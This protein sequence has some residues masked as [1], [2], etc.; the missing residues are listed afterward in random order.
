MPFWNSQAETQTEEAAGALQTGLPEGRGEGDENRYLR[1]TVCA[2]FALRAPH[3][4]GRCSP[5]LISLWGRDITNPF[6][7]WRN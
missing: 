6:T 5:L 2:G 1:S 7:R 4:T 3:P